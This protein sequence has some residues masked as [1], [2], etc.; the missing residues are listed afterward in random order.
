MPSKNN[1]HKFTERIRK[2][3]DPKN[4][5]SWGFMVLPKSVSDSLPRRGRLTAN[6]ELNGAMS[7]VTLEPDGKLSHWLRID[8]ALMKEAGVAFGDQVEVNLD[9]LEQEPNPS[10]PA[11]FAKALKANP[12]ALEI[13]NL[14]TAIAQIDWIHWI[15][16]AKQAKTRAKRISDAADML[17]KGK[18]RV[19]CFDP[20][21]FYSKALSAP[22]ES[23]D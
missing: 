13:W 21:G 10:P 14:T 19:C 7:P 20:S 22:E 8:S 15:E 17:A 12:K 4:A 18:K 3:S 6:V 23:I 2:P 9:P 5:T 1:P 16:S 11:D